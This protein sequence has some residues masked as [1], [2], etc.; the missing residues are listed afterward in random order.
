[1]DKRGR[2]LAIGEEYDIQLLELVSPN[3]HAMM[4]RLAQALAGRS[5]PVV[6]VAL[7]KAL[8]RAGL[9]HI[10]EPAV[11]LY[12]KQAGWS[13]SWWLHGSTPAQTALAGWSAY[14]CT[15]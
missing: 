4:K 12:D 10:V 13:R 8:Q 6:G 15:K 5:G 11:Q 7:H 14:P 1:M 9:Q 2:S 3:S